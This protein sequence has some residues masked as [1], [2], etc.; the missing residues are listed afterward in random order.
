MKILFLALSLLAL[1]NPAKAD[2]ALKLGGYLESSIN[3]FDGKNEVTSSN[4][5]FRLEGN[6]DIKNKG[7]IESHL[8]YHYDMK[9]LD[10][11]H[12]F[13]DKSIYSRIINKYYQEMY[14]G[15]EMEERI[16]ADR[17]LEIY[18]SGYFDH[19]SYSSFYPKE[20]IVLDRALIK[21]YYETFDI[22]FG[23]QQIAWG[24]GY[25]FNPTDV[26]NIK[27]PTAPDASKIGV[28]A[29]NL[30]FY[31]GDNSSLQII[32]SPGSDFDHWKYGARIKS[33]AGRFEY[34]F[35]AIRDKTDDGDLLGI[36]EKIQIGGDLSGEIFNEIG[37]RFEGAF[38]NPRY[39][40]MAASDTD[41]SYVQFTT[42]FDYTFGNGLYFL[43]EYYYNGLGEKRNSDYDIRSFLRLTGGEMSGL[44]ENYAAFAVSYTLK[45][46]YILSIVSVCNIDDNSAVFVPEIEY[47][48][49][50]NISV[51][52]GADIFA[53][54]SER[55][56]F[57]GIFNSISLAVTGFF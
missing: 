40:G 23:K 33:T 5:L 30:A 22:T 24:T 29:V 57:G 20:T 25:A 1:L 48:F 41:S 10:P 8:L 39:Y 42:G 27:D 38:L 53:G 43:T 45:N 50:E 31:F 19:L 55:S 32:T 46:D 44:A 49:D 35:S 51:K 14:D 4:A 17:L 3:Y 34:S 13:K 2:D 47:S 6:Y 16:V 54:S 28:L 18:S 36:P 56:E 37:Y 9:P 26:W 7:K 11:F 15:L 12:T 52:L 21:L